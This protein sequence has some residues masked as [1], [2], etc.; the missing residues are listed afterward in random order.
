MKKLV[1]K[2]ATLCQLKESTKPKNCLW[3]LTG[4]SAPPRV[5]Q[6]EN[7]FKLASFS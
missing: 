1:L 5:M 4:I 2:A 7:K 6:L 3:I